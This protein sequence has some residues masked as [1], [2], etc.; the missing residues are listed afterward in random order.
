VSDKTILIVEDDAD[1][2]ETLADVFQDEGYAVTTARDG[3][4]ALATLSHVRP[5]V[6]ILDL[7]MPVMS[8]VEV[9]ATMQADARLKDIPVIVSTS[10]PTRAP[11]SVLV[12]K[13]PINLDRLVAAVKQFC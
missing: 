7:I 10:D 8:G 12:M 5:C 13:K 4:E 6:I 3:T 11:A 9:F 2:R 1:I